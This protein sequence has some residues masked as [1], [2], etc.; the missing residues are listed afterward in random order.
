[1]NIRRKSLCLLLA[2]AS[3][4]MLLAGCKTTPAA[5]SP[6]AAATPSASPMRPAQT[7]EPSPLPTASPD[8][9]RPPIGLYI[10]EEGTGK[11]TRVTTFTSPWTPGK[12]IDCFEAI[13][14]TEQT[15]LGGSFRRVW[16][17]QWD[18]YPQADAYRIGFTLSFTLASGQQVY[19]TILGPADITEDFTRYVEVYLYDD[20]HQ[21]AGVRYSHLLESEMD[22]QTLI[23]S[24][25]L[26]AGK[27]IEQVQ[28]IQLQAFVYRN[29]NEF[30]AQTGVYTGPGGC[31]ISI[32]Q[33]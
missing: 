25:K 31:T 20:I 17:S 6:T 13:A 8:P 24:I 10:P 18:R 26:T 3:A 28:A 32:Q 1:M 2:A 12:D 5:P 16:Q 30:D 14:C 9:D 21:Q 4:A 19:K 22:E 15:L 29:E 11:R 27:E 23:T 7:A 33:S